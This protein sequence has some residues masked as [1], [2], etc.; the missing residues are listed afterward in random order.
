V[1]RV[2]TKLC[3]LPYR[4]FLVFASD[5]SRQWSRRYKSLPRIPTFSSS[6][7]LPTL[8]SS[9]IIYCMPSFQQHFNHCNHG[10]LC[11]AASHSCI[12]SLLLNAVPTIST[13]TIYLAPSSSARRRTDSPLLHPT[14]VC[15]YKQGIRGRRSLQTCS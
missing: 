13:R 12:P 3:P 8:F 15:L 10:T 1:T 9:F 7:P 11:T 6:C 5:A 14:T 4:P 2:G